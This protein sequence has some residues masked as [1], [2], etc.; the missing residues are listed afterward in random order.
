MTMQYDS[1]DSGNWAQWREAILEL[2]AQAYEASRRDRPETLEQIILD[3]RG[4]SLAAIDGVDGHG[5]APGGSLSPSACTPSC[6][7]AEPSCRGAGG[8]RARARGD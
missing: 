5:A 7:R 1:L 2:E 3:R 4:A 6:R 8:R